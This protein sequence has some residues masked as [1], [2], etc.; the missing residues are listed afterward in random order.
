MKRQLAVFLILGSVVI[1]LLEAPS[2][3]LA[4]SRALRGPY[5]ELERT[6]P[7]P[8][9]VSILPALRRVRTSRETTSSS[10]SPGHPLFLAEN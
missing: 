3:V 2:A 5:P 8:R 10:E 1:L 9:R 7:L 4:V 6:S